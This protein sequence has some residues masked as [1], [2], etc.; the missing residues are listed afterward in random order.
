MS[1][2]IFLAGAAVFF[3]IHILTIV[4]EVRE[5]IA[6]KRGANGYKGAFTLLSLAS[7]AALI[8]GYSTVE[9]A[10]VWSP[11]TAHLWIPLVLMP[12]SFLFLG[13]AYASKGG[14]RIVRHPMLWGMLV[15]AVS[16]LMA[17]GDS[18]SILFFGAMAVYSVI[19]QPL[20]DRRDRLRQPVV[21]E[22]TAGST[23]LI[24]FIALASGR[25]KLYPH[26][27][28][29]LPFVVAAAGFTAFLLLH[30]FLFGASPLPVELM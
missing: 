7:F 11:P 8:Y 12:I 22:A 4:P 1:W 9:P 18:A 2:M 26:P 21:Y 20:S 23:S 16:H 19:A 3:A 27:L 6:G 10:E 15:W 29:W 13:C 30:P 28:G 5:P 25:A 14:K 24:P 17:N